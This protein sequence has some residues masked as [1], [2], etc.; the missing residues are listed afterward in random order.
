[1][2]LDAGIVAVSPASVWRV[3]GRAG[4]LSKWN[5]KPSKKGTG[6]EHRLAA[7]QHWHIDFSYINISGT[8]YYLCSIRAGS[9][10][11]GGQKTAPGS[12]SEGRVK[13]GGHTFRAARVKWITSVYP[14]IRTEP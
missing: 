2:M 11:G 12:S 9:E 4:L 5:G 1:M 13:N 6:F 8:F 7:H 3:L 14:A 10:V